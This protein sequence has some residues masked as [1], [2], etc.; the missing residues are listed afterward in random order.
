MFSLDS[1]MLETQIAKLF[2][3]AIEIQESEQISDS[4][5]RQL[6]LAHRIGGLGKNVLDEFPNDDETIKHDKFIDYT[7]KKGNKAIAI[8]R[9]HTKFA[10]AKK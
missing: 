5:F 6:V 8:Y 9:K 1:E 3:D 7:H 4:T 2:Q 10:T